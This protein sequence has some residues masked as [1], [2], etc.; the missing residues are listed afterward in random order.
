MLCKLTP[1]WTTKAVLP[2]AGSTQIITCE[3]AIC[4]ECLQDGYNTAAWQKQAVENMIEPQATLAALDKEPR[5]LLQPL[6]GRDWFFSWGNYVKTALFILGMVHGCS[7]IS[8]A[9]A[10]TVEM[11]IAT[12][13]AECQQTLERPHTVVDAG[14]LSSCQR[15]ESEDGNTCPTE[16]ERSPARTSMGMHFAMSLT[17]NSLASQLPRAAVRGKIQCGGCCTG[18]HAGWKRKRQTRGT[19]SAVLRPKAGARDGPGLGLIP[20]P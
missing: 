9:V 5:V 4:T 6:S 15:S 12:V 20:N 11:P 13:R 10:H 17:R 2:S 1:P 8:G 16:T 19:L 18:Q 3:L 7:G 14:S